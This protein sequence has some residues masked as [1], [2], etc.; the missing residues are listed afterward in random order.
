MANKC[1]DFWEQ[2]WKLTSAE[3]LGVGYTKAKF[4][5]EGYSKNSTKT[6]I[7]MLYHTPLSFVPAY[8]HFQ[9]S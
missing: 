1:Q 8:A 4:F 5:N 7:S 2:A 6:D 9:A 3:N